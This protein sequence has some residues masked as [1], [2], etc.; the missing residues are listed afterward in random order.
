M[1]AMT[2]NNSTKVK[3]R[4]LDRREE[5]TI[6]HPNKVNGKT[7]GRIRWMK[8]PRGSQKAGGE[9][10]LRGLKVEGEKRRPKDS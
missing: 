10:Y 8:R 9:S 1:I 2:T 5:E 6:N 7:A 4:R 3:P